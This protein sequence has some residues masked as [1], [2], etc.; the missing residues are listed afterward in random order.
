MVAGRRRAQKK[1]LKST[2]AAVKVAALN[3]KGHGNLN[4]SHADNKWAALNSM[5]KAEK[6]GILIVGEAH[7]NAERHEALA[8]RYERSMEILYSAASSNAAGIAIVLNKHLIKTESV[9]SVEIKK[10]RAILVTVNWHGTEKLSVLG[11]YADNP[12]LDNANLW[13]SIEEYFEEN[14]T[15]RM[16]DIMAGDLNVVE[17]ALDRLPPRKDDDKPVQALDSLMMRLGLTDGWRN[18]N[19]EK[20]AFTHDHAHGKSRLDRIYA[21]REVMECS[22]EWRITNT[23]IKTDHSMVSVKVAKRSSPKT[24]P[25]RWRMPAFLLSNSELKAKI[26]QMGRSTLDM[27]KHQT[28]ITPNEIQTDFRNFKEAVVKETKRWERIVTSK[29]AEE[30]RALEKGMEDILNDPA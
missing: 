23:G 25:G 21:T 5:I 16:P 14:P 26:K 18:E 24:G 1:N 13:S 27:M 3:I 7:M 17:S 9:K 8:K 15:T 4:L 28:E 6:V 22:T 10:G 30:I 29:D 20:L 19:P 2:R 12:P 11:V